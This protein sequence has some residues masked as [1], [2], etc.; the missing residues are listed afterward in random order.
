MSSSIVIPKTPSTAST[1]RVGESS[2][3]TSAS[4]S[5]SYSDSP[6]STTSPSVQAQ[7]HKAS[8][9]RRPSLLSMFRTQGSRLPFAFGVWWLTSITGT[10]ISKQECTTIN[11]GDPDGPPRLVRT[12]RMWP[13]SLTSLLTTHQLSYLSSS[14]GYLWNP[15]MFAVCLSDNCVLT[16]CP[17]IFLPPYVDCDYVPLENRRDPVHD[18]VLSD[19]ESK[20]MLPQ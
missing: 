2:S 16:A 15:G 20:S 17:E 9:Q 14:Q 1:Y 5:S 12:F 6:R 7:K 10:A 4:S 3:K 11:I 8:H 19:E 13:R 18:I